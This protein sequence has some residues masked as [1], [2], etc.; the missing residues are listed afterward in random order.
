MAT[1]D[2]SSPAATRCGPASPGSRTRIRCRESKVTSSLSTDSAKTSQATQPTSVTRP[3]RMLP[4]SR[5]NRAWRTDS[6][7]IVVG[8]GLPPNAARAS[9]TPTRPT[10]SRTSAPSPRRTRD[11]TAGHGVSGKKIFSIAATRKIRL[12]INAGRVM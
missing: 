3:S 2:T 4:S 9:G 11:A 10:S 5:R 12:K 8:S 6:Q 1:T 7:V